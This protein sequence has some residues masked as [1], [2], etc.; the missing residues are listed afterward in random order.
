VEE[1][2]P[3]ETYKSE[4][5]LSRTFSERRGLP[6]RLA[7]VALEEHVCSRGG[8]KLKAEGDAQIQGG[9]EVKLASRA[10]S[11]YILPS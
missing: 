9:V 4:E 5:E 11:V 8:R 7:Y 10:H 2:D 6:E 1:G 3:G